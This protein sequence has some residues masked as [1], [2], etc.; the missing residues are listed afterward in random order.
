MVCELRRLAYT[1]S[2]WLD[3][4]LGIGLSARSSPFVWNLSGSAAVLSTFLK[5]PPSLPQPM[6]RTQCPQ[7]RFV[8]ARF[9]RLKR[10]VRNRP[11]VCTSEPPRTSRTHVK[12]TQL[13]Q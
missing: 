10:R 1:P 5:L 3:P 7:H 2:A 9:G 12:R 11:S 8:S 13:S 4:L 6:P